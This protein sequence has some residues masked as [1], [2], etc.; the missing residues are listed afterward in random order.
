MVLL[1]SYHFS[2][3]QSLLLKWEVFVFKQSV[4]RC[5]SAPAEIFWSC[6]FWSAFTHLQSQESS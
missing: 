3:R 5:S 6:S 2:S 4:C 1:L